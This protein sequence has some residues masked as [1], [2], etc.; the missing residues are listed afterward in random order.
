MEE[1]EQTIDLRVLWKILKDH[2]LPIVACAIIAAVVGLV[3]SIAVIPK[4]F[5]SEATMVVKNTDDSSTSTL[6][7]INDI[8]AAQKMVAT[9]QI[10]FTTNHVLSEL[11]SSFG[12][13]SI[14][15]LKDM[16]VIEAVNNTEILKVSVTTLN[17]QTS[18]D[19]AT[20]LTELA[21]TEFKS[22]YDNGSIKLLSEPQYPE[23]PTF[24]SVPMFTV[25][26][27]F[28][29]LVVSY[30]VFLVIEMVD[31]KVKPDDDLMQLY[32]I[33]VFAEIMNFELSDKA[34]YK[35]NYYSH[36]GSESSQKPKLKTDP[37][38]K[39]IEG[40]LQDASVADKIGD[41]RKENA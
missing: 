10:V 28:I 38:V 41:K 21:M 17:A 22:V 31:I 16:I 23:A 29:G 25:V 9:C 40:K 19:I 30:I 37:N 24:P 4:Q 39:P 36:T 15:E 5:T 14:N 12:N 20:K 2:W 18:T 33:P 3:L 32:G 34:S 6:L 35:Y 7:N 27:L 13:Y 26:G 1:N 8:N 11:Q